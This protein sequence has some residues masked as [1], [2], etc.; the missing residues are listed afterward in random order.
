M[1][2]LTDRFTLYVDTKRPETPERYWV[3]LG[4]GTYVY[5]ELQ[6]ELILHPVHYRNVRPDTRVLNSY[7]NPEY[8]YALR[9]VVT[10]RLFNL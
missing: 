4:L 3:S 8:E 7:P 10:K 9:E 5:R 6:G 1:T 2:N